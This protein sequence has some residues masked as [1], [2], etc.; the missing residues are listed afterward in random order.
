[1]TISQQNKVFNNSVRNVEQTNKELIAIY[2]KAKDETEKKLARLKIKAEKGLLAEFQEKRIERLNAFI[3]SISE[4]IKKLKMAEYQI[5]E[6]G[7]IENYVNSYYG[8]GYSIE[9]DVNKVLLKAQEY[10]Y[11]LGY[12]KLNLAEVR[13]I[14]ESEIA[15][16]VFG[17]GIAERQQLEILQ[18]QANIRQ[19]V[20]Q[21][22]VEGISPQ[23]LARRLKNVDEVYNQNL[24]GAL[25]VARTEMLSA[26][27]LGADTAIQ[28]A[29]DAGVTGKKIWNATLDGRT[30]PDHGRM[31]SKSRAGEAPDKDG[32]FVFSD[33]KGRRPGDFSLS[34]K[35]RINCR[36]NLNF[37]VRGVTPNSRGFRGPNGKWAVRNDDISYME[38]AE[39]L[40]GKQSIEAAQ[41][42][43]R[44]RAKR[45]SKKS[46]E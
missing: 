33:S 21:A 6:Q 38:W 28:Q 40:Q 43:K 30:R 5:I 16:N 45:L 20:T 44:A 17:L 26:H 27:N 36:C 13:K 39:T 9:Y 25:R 46:K 18:L 10:D 24:N 19:S 15:S 42:D 31:D 11:T 12:R 37:R 2:E 32:F 4:D 23:E 7:V 22:L 3:K 8:Y 1:M 14:Y 35:Q 41:K 29:Q 34:K